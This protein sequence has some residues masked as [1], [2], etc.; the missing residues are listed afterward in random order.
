M[1]LI[2][3]LDR[4]VAFHRVFVSLTGSITG[5]LLL[6]QSVYWQKRCQHEDGWWWKTYEEWTEET[7]MSR[8]ELNSARKRCAEFLKCERRG[9]PC[10]N[11]YTLDQSAL[12]TGIASILDSRP[13]IK[14]AGIPRSGWRDSRDLLSTETTSETTYKEVCLPLDGLSRSALQ[15]RVGQIFGRRV[16]TKWN[17]KEMADF[18]NIYPIPVEDIEV[19]EKFYALKNLPKNGYRRTTLQALLSFWNGE[20]EK[21]RAYRPEKENTGY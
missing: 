17:K 8:E 18:G 2:A 3:L 16:G 1:S 7:G 11:F 10:R 21:A 5:A 19:V 4:P 12:E 6:S 9:V 13:A 20:V 15:F 14:I